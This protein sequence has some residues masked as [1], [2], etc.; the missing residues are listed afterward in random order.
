MFRNY[1]GKK[2][3]IKTPQL[4]AQK[5]GKLLHPYNDLHVFDLQGGL[6]PNSFKKD[7]NFCPKCGSRNLSAVFCIPVG[8]KSQFSQTTA[9]LSRCTDCR[10]EDLYGGFEKTNIQEERDR[11]LNLI[12]DGV[13]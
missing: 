12:L 7:L 6:V 13:Q 5:L 10:Y 3:G 8:G 4:S 1:A 9:S 11:K 2:K